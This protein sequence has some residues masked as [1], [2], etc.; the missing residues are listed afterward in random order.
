MRLV[1]DDGASVSLHPAAYEF[2][3]ATAGR[4][5]QDWDANW[6]II[7]GEVHTADG[8]Q[9]AFA[10]PCLTT[11][12]ARRLSAWLHGAASGT[13]G[14]MSVAFTEPNVAFCLAGHR[15]GHLQ[16]RVCFSHEALPPW[17]PRDHDGWRAGEYALVLDISR[18]DLAQAAAVW[19][20]EHEPFPER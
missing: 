3:A 4:D 1:S 7:H 6:L 17:V 5:Q 8:R 16:L 14:Q 11:W 9:W 10:H 15:A 12:E 13:A 18:E 2:E 19:D 20:L